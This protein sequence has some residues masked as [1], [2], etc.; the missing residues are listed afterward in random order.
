MEQSLA[1]KNSETRKV[2]LVLDASALIS[3]LS[4]EDIVFTIRTSHA[5]SRTICY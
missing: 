3:I 5:G 1:N 2:F 4:Q